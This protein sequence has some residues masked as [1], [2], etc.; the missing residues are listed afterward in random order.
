[1]RLI[2]AVILAAVIVW[3]P[4]SRA[5]AHEGNPDGQQMPASY[6]VMYRSNPEQVWAVA[7]P[8]PAAKVRDV[9]DKL[10]AR[11]F[12]VATSDATNG[13]PPIPP[14]GP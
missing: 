5:L 2:G 1:M 14:S 9:V 7:G 10:R 4:G 11:G 8:V 12:Q 3:Q 13:Q 6:W